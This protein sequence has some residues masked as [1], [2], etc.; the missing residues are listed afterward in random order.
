LGRSRR[1]SDIN[2]KMGL[3]KLVCKGKRRMELAQERVTSGAE[4]SGS[5]SRE[6]VFPLVQI[7]GPASLRTS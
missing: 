1:R 2:I 5:A 7:C 4:P 6:F 3:I